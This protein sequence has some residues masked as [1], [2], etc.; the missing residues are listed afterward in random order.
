MNK[1][2]SSINTPAEKK[3][4]GRIERVPQ[5]VA[6]FVNQALNKRSEK[7]YLFINGTT[8]YGTSPQF[9]F[10]SVAFVN[11]GAVL[12]Q[13]ASSDERIG[14]R[15][16]C[17]AL[18]IRLELDAPPNQVAGT[19]GVY[20]RIM[21]I[22]DRECSTGNTLPPATDIMRADAVYSQRNVDGFDRYR[23]LADELVQGHSIFPS[24]AAN[25]HVRQAYHRYVKMNVSTT[26]TQAGA[27]SS[28]GLI[29]LVGT[30]GQQ[31]GVGSYNYDC[32]LTFCDQ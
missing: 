7:K 12:A 28:G 25:D 10:L 5:Q 23:V 11:S 15:V 8:N 16:L 1:R 31:A 17:K 18:D 4:K 21:V 26:Y 2:R 32:K 30:S 20:Y 9:S 13:G 29:V 22:E 27:L 14:R 24:G 3:S 19:Q 6:R